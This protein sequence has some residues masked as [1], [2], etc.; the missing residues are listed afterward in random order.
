MDIGT[1]LLT[2]NI[3]ATSVVIGLIIKYLLLLRKL[4]S[5]LVDVLEGMLI[6]QDAELHTVEEF[7]KK[8]NDIYRTL[9][10]NIQNFSNGININTSNIKD[11]QNTMLECQKIVMKKLEEIPSYILTDISKR[12]DFIDTATQTSLQTLEDKLN[13][14]LTIPTTKRKPTKNPVVTIHNRDKKE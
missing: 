1:I 9:S 10:D 11:T 3:S 12:Q 4:R 5:D 8:E 14:L 13:I 6:R 2:F 7:I